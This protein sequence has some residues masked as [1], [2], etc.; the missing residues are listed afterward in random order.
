MSAGA[1]RRLKKEVE[2]W[3]A[4]TRL[5]IGACRVLIGYFGKKG[6]LRSWDAATKEPLRW[7]SLVVAHFSSKARG[8]KATPPFRAGRAFRCS[9]STAR[10]VSPL[11]EIVGGP[12]ATFI[13]TIRQ[14]YPR[15]EQSRHIHPYGNFSVSFA[16][17][18]TQPMWTRYRDLAP[19]YW[20]EVFSE[21]ATEE[22]D[23]APAKRTALARRR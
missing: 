8:E 14:V 21:S 10:I 11:A 16:D 17:A 3:A 1:G 7:V 18:V 22:P 4:E 19:D 2:S 20:K 6:E 9:E 15:A 5:L 13:Y 23:S 12:V